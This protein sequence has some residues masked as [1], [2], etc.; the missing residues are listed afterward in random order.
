MYAREYAQTLGGFNPVSASLTEMD[1]NCKPDRYG[2]YRQK[3]AWAEYERLAT[4]GFFTLRK[5]K[6]D[7]EAKAEILRLKKSLRRTA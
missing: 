3:S 6:Q 7:V 2:N 1:K 5:R 4:K